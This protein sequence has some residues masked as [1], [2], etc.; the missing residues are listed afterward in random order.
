MICTRPYCT[1]P[2]CPAKASPGRCT[3]D[4]STSRLRPRPPATRR[5]PSPR[6]S[7]A[8]SSATA[9]A[10]RRRLAF[11]LDEA[12]VAVTPLVEDVHAG[13]GRVAEH[14]DPVVV[15][16]DLEHRLVHRHRLHHEAPGAD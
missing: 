8:R 10:G 1:Y 9:T 2:G 6:A 12:E 13:R 7:R 5:S 3:R 14:H 16:A 11:R 15:A 4:N